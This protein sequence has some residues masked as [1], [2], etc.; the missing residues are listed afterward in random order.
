MRWFAFGTF[1]PVMRLHGDRDP[2]TKKALISSDGKPCAGSGADNEI[3]SYG[4]NVEKVLRKFIDIRYKLKPYIKKVANEAHENGSPMMRTLF[5][6]FESD[7][8]AWEIEDEYMLGSDLLVAPVFEAGLTER[9]VYLPEGKTWVEV[10]TGAKFEGGKTV[11][12]YAPVEVIPV[13]ARDGSEV[14]DLLK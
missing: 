2:H 1:S 10:A 14:L 4:E 9:E 3:W 13:F 6:E 5:Y 11:K 12:A 8:K 7:K